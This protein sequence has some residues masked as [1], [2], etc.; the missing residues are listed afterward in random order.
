MSAL[1][2]EQLKILQTMSQATNRMDLNML[3]Q[4]VNLTP[5]QTMEQIQ[6]LA[7]IGLLKRIGAGYAVSDQGRTALKVYAPLPE[8]YEF[9]FYNAIDQPTGQCAKTIFEFYQIIK[10]AES[11]SLEFHLYR[12]DFEHWVTQSLNDD[13]LAKQV[14]AIKDFGYK[15]EMLRE[16]LLEV[17]DEKYAIRELA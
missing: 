15:G 10:Q 8:G 13:A 12:D 2:D 17:I 1:K 6:E 14:A 16:E 9:N 5:D 11:V 4:K 7:K 3:S